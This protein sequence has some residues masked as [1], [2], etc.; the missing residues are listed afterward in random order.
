MQKKL[1]LLSKMMHF[2]F[3]KLAENIK[4]IRSLGQ[5][6]KQGTAP[7]WPVASRWEAFSMVLIKLFSNT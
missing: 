7:L 3:A 6:L 5:S 4:A 2:L 1:D